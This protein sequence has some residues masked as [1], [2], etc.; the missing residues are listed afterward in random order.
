MSATGDQLS[1][2]APPRCSAQ[3][4]PRAKN[5]DHAVPAANDLRLMAR[6]CADRLLIIPGGH[7]SRGESAASPTEVG[8]G[9]MIRAQA[10]Q[11]A[12]LLQSPANAGHA[13]HSSRYI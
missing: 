6:W 10:A 9:G 12:Y 2:V 7:C 3:E 13:L 8:K 11:M 5:G 4:R 1:A